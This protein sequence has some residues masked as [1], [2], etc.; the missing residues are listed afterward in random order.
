M[1]QVTVRRIKEAW[2]AKAKTEARRRGLS[3][4]D[5]LREALASGLGVAGERSRK[6]NLDK[7]A[8]DSDFGPEW[9]KFLRE[10]LNRIDEEVWT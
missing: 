5:V 1:T 4:N 9:D 7:Y 2:V 10:D 6:S 3:M 8:G